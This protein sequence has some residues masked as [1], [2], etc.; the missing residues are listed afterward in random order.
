MM[1]AMQDI[2]NALPS[3]FIRIQLPAVEPFLSCQDV[4][5]ADPF[6]PDQPRR[7]PLNRKRG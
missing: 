3:H 1:D 2:P 6:G 5:I 4:P 7:D